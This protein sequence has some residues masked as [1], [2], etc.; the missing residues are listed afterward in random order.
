[1][2]ERKLSDYLKSIVEEEINFD[3]A[4]TKFSIEQ[5]K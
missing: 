2:D 1:M 3:K 4:K 5:N